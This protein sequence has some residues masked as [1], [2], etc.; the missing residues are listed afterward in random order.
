MNCERKPLT[1]IT[2]SPTFF[3]SPKKFGEIASKLKRRNRRSA[4]L[5]S[6]RRL[7]T[8]PKLFL[9]NSDHNEPNYGRCETSFR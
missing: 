9:F 2:D 5:A 1:E 8:F 4:Q 6:M 7:I 3:P